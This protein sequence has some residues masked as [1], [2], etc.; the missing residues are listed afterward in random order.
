MAKV[1]IVLPSY[2]HA[3]FLNDRLESILNQTYKDWEIIIIDDKSTDKSIDILN[4]FVKKNKSKIKHFIVNS[5]N[6]GS[7]YL[8]WKKGIELAKT[9]YIWIAETDD[10]SDINFLSNSIKVLNEN[11]ECALTFC[12]S[13]YVDINK[14]TLYDS[15]ARTKN[16][17]VDND[18]CK[19]FNS[20]ILENVLPFNTYITN[21]SSVVFKKPKNKI[22]NEI[23][24]NKQ[25]S[26]I[27]L[28]TYLVKNKSFAFINKKLNYFRRHEDSTTSK[29][30]E[31]DKESVYYEK[32][33]YLNYFSCQEKYIEFINHYIKHIVNANK[34][35]IFDIS[36][37]LKIEK[38]KFLRLK[39][40]QLLFKFYLNK[41]FR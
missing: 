41:I 22:P 32:A 36:A 10:Y 18:D 17:Y 12:T 2:N 30:S 23:F 15:T 33:N 20:L 19:V 34:M 8:S 3:N 31:L 13:V 24:I 5:K 21:G 7:G 25:S 16:L 4:Q 38:I 26:D 28:W 9:E 40:L 1:T 6:S 37:I 27:F 11:K 29:I 14:K 39:Y 35:K